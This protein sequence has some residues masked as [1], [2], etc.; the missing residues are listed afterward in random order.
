MVFDFRTS[1]RSELM[2]IKIKNENIETVETYKY[3]GT[4]I[5]NY[6]GQTSVQPFL[7][8]HNKECIFL[9]K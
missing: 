7:L 6:H 3:L 5:T 1:K 9:G 8:S 4:A 2:P